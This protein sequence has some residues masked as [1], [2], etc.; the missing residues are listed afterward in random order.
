VALFAKKFRK[1]LKFNKGS[2]KNPSLNVKDKA[3]NASMNVSFM[4]LTAS[5]ENA[6][7]Y[8]DCD[9][10][11]LVETC[12]EE[13][14]G[15]LIEEINLQEAYNQLFMKLNEVE[16]EKESLC[17]ELHDVNS[18]IDFLRYNN[19]LFVNKVKSLRDDLAVCKFDLSNSSSARLNCILSSQKLFWDK[20]GFGFDKNASTLKSIS[21]NK[22]K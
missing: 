3:L 14:Q 5:V 6:S 15:D 11:I 4:T 9:L 19:S 20:C 10:P 8:C 13:S 7:G 1:F 22:V 21:A 16:I 12:N 17:G 2:C 18:I